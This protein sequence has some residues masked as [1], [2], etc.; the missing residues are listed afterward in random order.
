MTHVNNIIYFD[1]S[2]CGMS[3][4]HFE[5]ILEMVLKITNPAKMCQGTERIY[6]DYHLSQAGR[7]FWDKVLT[8]KLLYGFQ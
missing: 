8:L 6:Y 7:K 1:Q 3:F 5:S 4:K 2:H